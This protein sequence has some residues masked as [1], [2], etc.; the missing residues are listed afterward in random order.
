MSNESENKNDNL[1]QYE[2]WWN[3]EPHIKTLAKGVLEPWDEEDESDNIP[4]KIVSHLL[5]N[6]NSNI[7]DGIWIMFKG[8]GDAFSKDGHGSSVKIE[9]DDGRIRLLVWSDINREDYTHSIYL[10]GALESKRPKIV[11]FEG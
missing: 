9:I 3:N 8:Y 2:D 5:V 10:D 1:Q 4:F 6:D 11:D 7:M